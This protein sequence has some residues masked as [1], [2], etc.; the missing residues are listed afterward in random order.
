VRSC[1]G[2]TGRTDI[3]HLRSLLDKLY[4]ASCW[5][6]AACIGLIC[7]LVVCQV[8]LNL[9]DRLSTLA[10]GSAI[11]LTIPSY[12]DFT[13]FLLAA[14][15]FLSLAYTLRQGAHIRVVLVTSR[16]PKRLYGVVEGWC[17]CFAL[18]VCLYFTWYTAQLTVESYTYND[19][20][21]GMIAVPIWIPQLF[22]LLGLAILCIA[23]A[24]ELVTVLRGKIP[25]YAIEVEQML[26]DD[27]GK[28]R[29]A[30][31]EERADA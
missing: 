24:D 28:Q 5:L 18:L 4:A 10:T 12:S 21:S 29:G 9:L 30:V 17:I 27:E 11:G 7:L 16:L 14:A 23:L 6:A 8:S 26:A 19:L 1:L 3:L 2:N 22:M 13:G 20:S 31:K 15:S 25:S